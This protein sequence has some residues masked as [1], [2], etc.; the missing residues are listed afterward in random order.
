MA[1]LPA[2]NNSTTARRTYSLLRGALFS[3]L[4]AL[5]LEQITLTDICSA[6]LISRSTFYRYFEDKYDLLHYYMRTLL[7]ETGLNEDVLYLTNSDS[8]RDFLTI[9]I[10]HISE[11]QILY[12]KIY[13]ANKDGDLIRIIRQGLIQIMNEKIQ[14]AEKKGYR[15]KLPAPIFTSL[16]VDF[17]FD[18][19]K[20]YL[21]QAD[22]CTTEEFLNG[23]CLFTEKDF[24]VPPEGRS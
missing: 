21:E 23:I 20:C 11:N 4:S 2:K 10:R 6:A 18:I 9:L 12:Q 13:R 3:Q 19:V 1:H 8:V 5:P 17:Y 22:Q 14:E 24:F 15:L 16:M 7:D